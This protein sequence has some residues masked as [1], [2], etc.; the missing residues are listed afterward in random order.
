M[1]N[2][3]R[4]PPAS[5]IHQGGKRPRRRSN[6]LAPRDRQRQS[7]LID[8]LCE[9]Y[10]EAGR[11]EK[12]IELAWESLEASGSL[13][14]YK[15]LVHVALLADVLD[16]WRERGRSVLRRERDSP[17][18]KPDRSELVAALL[19]DDDPEE[20]WREAKEGGCRRDLWLAL[21]RARER[22][23]PA[24]AV[25]VY[26]AQIEPA[27]HHSDNHTYAGAVEWLEKV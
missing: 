8:F 17:L 27:I 15:R 24:D 16:S 25:E 19:W 18:G 26:S 1:K 6:R 14:A 12:A 10:A 11:H 5:C 3:V 23:H 13:E 2:W 21:G 7:R 4:R 9:R 22:D 20:A